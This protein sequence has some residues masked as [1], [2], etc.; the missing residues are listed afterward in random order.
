MFKLTSSYH[1][2][3]QNRET[4]IPRVSHACSCE[5]V[6]QTLT[7]KFPMHNLQCQTNCLV[8]IEMKD[9][10]QVLRKNAS[11]KGT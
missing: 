3:E 2:Y 8:I 9:G 10:W 5:Y 4:R 11:F 1:R 7:R 6:G